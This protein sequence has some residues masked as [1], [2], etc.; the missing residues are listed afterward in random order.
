MND[1]YITC[2]ILMLGLCFAIYLLGTSVALISSSAAVP[3]CRNNRMKKSKK[4]QCRIELSQYEI[5]KMVQEK[6]PDDILDNVLYDVGHTDV[7]MH[8]FLD[9][10]GRKKLSINWQEAQ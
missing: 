5:L 3:M 8:S 2:L 6:Y 9:A 4:T 10:E 7:Q 1:K